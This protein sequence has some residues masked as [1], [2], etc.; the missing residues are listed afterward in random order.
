MSKVTQW[1]GAESATEAGSVT[2]Q[3]KHTHAKGISLQS[4]V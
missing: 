2:L 4:P 3:T 1:Q